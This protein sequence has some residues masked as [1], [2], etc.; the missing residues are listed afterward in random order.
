M[1]TLKTEV[2]R[3]GRGRPRVWYTFDNMTM[4]GSEWAAYLDVKPSVFYQR[5]R[6]HKANPARHPLAFVFKEHFE[7]RK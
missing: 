7:R 5:L 1:Y 4:L 2:E 3:Y 6:K